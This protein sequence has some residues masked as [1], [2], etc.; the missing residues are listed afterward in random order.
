MKSSQNKKRSQAAAASALL[1]AVML[2]VSACGEKPQ[3][4]NNNIQT[5]Q[6]DQLPSDKGI[7][8]SGIAINNEEDNE[9]ITTGAGEQVQNNNHAA[10]DNSSTQHKP[11][12]S[13]GSNDTNKDIGKA[14]KNAE[15]PALMKASGQYVGQAD[16]NQVEIIV[17]G[18]ALPF[19]LT[20]PVR[21]TIEKLEMNVAVDVEFTVEV[22]N[23]QE[24]I[25]H[26]WIQKITQKQ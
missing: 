8:D 19:R 6:Q 12:A 17:N 20:D 11:D 22:I 24:N 4:Q 26:R 25:V 10:P 21:D 13:Q 16:I 18:E 2:T 3:A 14:D 9:T 15:E 23:E 1:L 5:S 7:I